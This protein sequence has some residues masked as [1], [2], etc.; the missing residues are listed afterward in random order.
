MRKIT[1]TLLL[2]TG[3]VQIHAKK[4]ANPMWLDFGIKGGYMPTYMFNTTKINDENY[5]FN[6]SAGYAFGGKLGFNFSAERGITLDGLYS[7]SSFSD[8]I[9]FS[10]TVLGNFAFTNTVTT[11]SIDIPLMYRS[12][13]GD[14]SYFEIGPQLSLLRTANQTTNFGGLDVKSSFVSMNYA[15]VL[16]FGQYIG[17]NDKLG[18]FAGLRFGYTIN[19]VIE[20]S[21]KTSSGSPVYTPFRDIN[22]FKYSQSHPLFAMVLLEFNFD[23]GYIVSSKCGKATR[24]V[25]F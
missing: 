19:D 16:G 23:L 7:K 17:L 22:K 9:S 20:S 11:T 15:V 14:G 3:F 25:L 24:F 10:D 21:K 12:N 6:Y 8:K 2:L 13:G 1:L 5:S 4:N 18:L